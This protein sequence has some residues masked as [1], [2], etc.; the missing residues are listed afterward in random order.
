MFIYLHHLI[1]ITVPKIFIY[2]HHLNANYNNINIYLFTSLKEHTTLNW[3]TFRF[4]LVVTCVELLK[5]KQ[6]YNKL[7][8]RIILWK[9]NYVHLSFWVPILCFPHFDMI[10]NVAEARFNSSLILLVLMYFKSN[11]D[12]KGFISFFF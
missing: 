11:L 5:W 10:H 7:K 2:L 4:L 1:Q 9:L 6:S 8:V 12:K 3:A